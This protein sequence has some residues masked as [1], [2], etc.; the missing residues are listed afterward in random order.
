MG[1][2]RNTAITTDS[3]LW[4]YGSEQELAN[5]V[6]ESGESDFSDVHKGCVNELIRDLKRAGYTPSDVSNT[7]DFEPEVAYHVLMKIWL[8]ESA[9]GRSG[10]AEKVELYKSLWE[11]A[12]ANRHIEVASPGTDPGR[13]MPGVRNL[14][15]ASW[16]P[17]DANN[18][19]QRRGPGYGTTGYANFVKN[20]ED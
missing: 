6:V 8:S 12:K 20:Y 14:D 5:L 17:G 19:T 10:A 3:D 7:E 2:T 1:F 18:P 11:D 15:E 9:A 16:F 4:R 13:A